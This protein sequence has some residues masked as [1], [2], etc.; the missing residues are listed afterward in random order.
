MEHQDVSHAKAIIK[1][2]RAIR[3]HHL[4]KLLKDTEFNIST[5]ICSRLPKPICVCSPNINK[6]LIWSY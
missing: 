3:D 4:L 2:L 1:T 5:H 6:I